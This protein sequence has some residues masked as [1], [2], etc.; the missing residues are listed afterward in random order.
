MC[1][2][3]YDEP[4][5]SVRVPNAMIRRASS[6]STSGRWW[7]ERHVHRCTKRP[8]PPRPLSR[9]PR[10][11]RQHLLLQDARW[12]RLATTV[13]VHQLTQLRQRCAAVLQ[14]G[15][16]PIERR[17]P[18]TERFVHDRLDHF[19]C[20]RLCE[21][22]H[23]ARHR[24]HR[25]SLH[26]SE[27]A[28]AQLLNPV[29]NLWRRQLCR[30]SD[31]DLD[32]L[33]RLEVLEAPEPRRT[34]VRERIPAPRPGAHRDQPLKPGSWTAADDV[35]L[36]KQPHPGAHL[37]PVFNLPVGEVQPLRVLARHHSMPCCRERLRRAVC[38][39]RHR[40]TPS[41]SRHAHSLM[42]V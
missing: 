6:I 3:A 16:Q 32:R 41:P 26:L 1:C 28:H 23:R 9:S 37:Q 19:P 11:Q 35:D 12:N 20:A 29:Q 27:I 39:N 13:A 42:R 34:A 22:Q 30:A 4:S 25:E 24:G 33:V 31:R 38:L 10:E 7:I 2:P 5:L 21:I 14:G 15:L 18:A 36:G 40:P 17:S 8:L